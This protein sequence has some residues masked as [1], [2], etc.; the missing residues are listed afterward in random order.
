MNRTKLLA[1]TMLIAPFLAACSGRVPDPASTAPAPTAGPDSTADT[2]YIALAYIEGSET[3]A[4]TAADGSGT[5]HASLAGH[6][7]SPVRLDW[8]PDGDHLMC[9]GGGSAGRPLPRFAVFNAAGEFVIGARA[10]LGSFAW[11]PDGRRYAYTRVAANLQTGL[12][13]GNFSSADGFSVGLAESPVWLPDGWLAAYRPSGTDIGGSDTPFLDIYIG[14]EARSIPGDFRP[15]APILDGTAVLAASRY[16]VS[17]EFGGVTFEANIITLATREARR[18]PELDNR[19]RLFW[20]SPDGRRAVFVTSDPMPR[21]AF[22][23]F[24]TLAVTP[25]KDHPSASQANTYQ[26]A[27]SPSPGMAPSTGSTSVSR[28]TSTGSMLTAAIS[29]SSLACPRPYSSTFRRTGPASHSS[30]AEAR[31][32]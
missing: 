1:A 21:L 8:S 18:I 28:R 19:R 32:S 6:C 15:L 10:D 20:V 24:E 7:P 31:R 27:T 4:L 14:A 17:G 25:K 29:L 3:L 16:Q 5:R 23:D 12:F 13:V 2:D 11:A 22:I 26:R 30:S 9:E